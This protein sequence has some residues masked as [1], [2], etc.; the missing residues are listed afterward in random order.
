METRLKPARAVT[1]AGIPCLVWAEDALSFALFVP[2]KLFALQLLIPD[3]DVERATRAITSHLP[4]KRLAA[5]HPDWLDH[6]YIDPDQ[7]SCFPR[8]VRLELTTPQL[9]RSDDDPVDIY[10]HPS[11]YFSFEVRDPSHSHSHSHSHSLVPPLSPA[12]SALRFPTRTAFL[13]AV[14]ATVLDPPLGFRHG[15]LGLRLGSYVSYINT[16][17]LRARPRVLPNGDLEPEHASMLASLRP[18]NRHWYEAKV[19][20]KYDSW[21]EEVR[22]RRAV[23]ERIGCV[24]PRLRRHP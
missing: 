23:L 16:Y 18:E 5:P 3:E 17:T 6:K 14:I 20:G 9:L 1:N 7:S 21:V 13:D 24:G 2:T 11:S 12:N 22:A 4:Y 19:R 10:L 8:A 15:K